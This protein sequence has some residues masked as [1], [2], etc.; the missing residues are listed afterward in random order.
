MQSEISLVLYI[1]QL[2]RIKAVTI[3]IAVVV[4]DD[5]KLVR[6]VI[7]KEEDNRNGITNSIVCGESMYAT[8][9]L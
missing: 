8:K 9:E 4:P 6:G 3:I 5:E 2:V 1:V 7:I